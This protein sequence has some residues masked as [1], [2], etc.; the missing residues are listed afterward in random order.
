MAGRLGLAA[1]F[2]E[3]VYDA[4]EVSNAK[5][6]ALEPAFRRTSAETLNRFIDQLGG[7]FVGKGRM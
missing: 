2:G 5:I 6:A 4:G 3:H 1:A 7:R